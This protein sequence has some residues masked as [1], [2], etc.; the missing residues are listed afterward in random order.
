MAQTWLPG[1]LLRMGRGGCEFP[2]KVEV[3]VIWGG[4]G[5]V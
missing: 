3:G 4:N 1:L 2:E 5:E